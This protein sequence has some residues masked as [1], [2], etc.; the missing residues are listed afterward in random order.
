MVEEEEERKRG[1][2]RSGLCVRVCGNAKRAH[3]PR[4]PVSRRQGGERIDIVASLGET[5]ERRGREVCRPD[6]LVLGAGLAGCAQKAYT[7]TGNSAAKRG[8][9]SSSQRVRRRAQW[10]VENIAAE[11]LINYTQLLKNIFYYKKK[12]TLQMVLVIRTPK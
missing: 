2:S 3:T 10:A 8:A 1:E 12:K 6:G 5:G 7:C 9:E 4:S 11:N